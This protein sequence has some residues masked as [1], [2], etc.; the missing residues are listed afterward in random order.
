MTV[1]LIAVLVASVVRLPTGA[2]AWIARRFGA[3][4]VADAIPRPAGALGYAGNAV[5]K[6]EMLYVQ[7]NVA[8]ALRERYRRPGDDVQRIMGYL[9]PLRRSL[10][11]Q[12]EVSHAPANWSTMLS[13]VGY[14]DQ[15]NAVAANVLAGEFGGAQLFA[16]SDSVAPGNGHTIGRVWSRGLNEWLYFD[17]WDE[18]VVFDV[19]PSG[20]ARTLSRARL[21][22]PVLEPSETASFYGLYDQTGN[23]WVLNEY[24]P[25]FL[26]YVLSKLRRDAAQ[27]RPQSLEPTTSVGGGTVAPLLPLDASADYRRRYASARVDQLLGSPAEARAEFAQIQGARAGVYSA[28]AKLFAGRIGIPER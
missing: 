17:L 10:L 18:P 28:A 27:R 25:T 11:N 14:C 19:G 26:G 4:M 22:P 5:R 2:T 3:W 9:V 7:Y 6:L 20:R 8:G 23:G 21:F 24:R 13:G 15:L 16:I 12:R 1:A